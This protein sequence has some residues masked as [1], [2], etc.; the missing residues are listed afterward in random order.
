MTDASSRSSAHGE[1]LLPPRSQLVGTLA[2]LGGWVVVIVPMI[3]MALIIF[4]AVT[5]PDGGMATVGKV[6][7]IFLGA[8]LLFCMI[9]APHLLGQAVIH[10]ERAMWR[11][12]AITG[13]PT[14]AVVLYVVFRWLSNLG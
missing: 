6:A 1:E 2:S 9:A 3:V 10:R 13:I 14:A 5:N 4:S 8:A 7:L 12:A 11:A